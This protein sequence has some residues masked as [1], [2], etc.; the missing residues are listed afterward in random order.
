MSLR[1]L[2]LRAKAREVGARLAGDA[3]AQVMAMII[4]ED[5][6]GDYERSIPSWLQLAK[7]EFAEEFDRQVKRREL[8]PSCPR[9]ASCEDYLP[10]EECD[11]RSGRI[12]YEEAERE[13]EEAFERW[14][15]RASGDGHRAA[16]D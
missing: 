1:E 16:D 14:T 3:V 13:A 6:A 12:S 5:G 4:R 10:R 2:A 8:Q 11:Y 9:H 7:E 15:A